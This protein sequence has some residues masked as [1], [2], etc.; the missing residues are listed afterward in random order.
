MLAAAAV[1]V[2]VINDDAMAYPN[3]I[4]EF[5]NVLPTGEPGAI[6]R[7]G[8]PPPAGAG[9]QGEENKEGQDGRG[10]PRMRAI[11]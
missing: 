6:R 4:A 3:L 7:Q 8:T 5:A 11:V 10:L 1:R 2:A 9:R